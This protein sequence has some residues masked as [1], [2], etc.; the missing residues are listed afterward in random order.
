MTYPGQVRVRGLRH[1]P[2]IHALAMQYPDFIA[3]LT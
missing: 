3:R 2:A 1:W